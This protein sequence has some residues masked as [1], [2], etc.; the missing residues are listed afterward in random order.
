MSIR[1]I[2]TL[3]LTLAVALPGCTDDGGGGD[4]GGDDC[5]DLTGSWEISGGCG[6]DLCTIDQSGC[7]LTSVSCVSGSESDSGSIDGNDFTYSGT[8][9]GGLPAMCLGTAD[10]DA[11]SGSCETAQGT[12][13]FTGARR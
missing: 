4:D 3:S 13:A 5:A 12:C 8:S 7:A 2:A 1:L 11:L 6:A 10:G 9:G